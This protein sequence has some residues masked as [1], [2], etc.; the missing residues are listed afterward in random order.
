MCKVLTPHE[1]QAVAY[2]RDPDQYLWALWASKESA[3]KAVSKSFPQVT[4]V[5]KRYPVFLTPN[6]FS[7]ISNGVVHTP[8]GVARVRLF[9]HEAYVHCVGFYNDCPD[10]N[11]IVWGVEKTLP[12]ISVE[13]GLLPAQQSI[14]VRQVAAKSIA[15]QLNLD[16]EQIQIKRKKSSRGLGPPIVYVNGNR[17]KIDISLSHHGRFGAYVFWNLKNSSCSI[18]Q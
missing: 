9:I 12:N 1:K 5:P 6:P 8:H 13:G 16:P 11:N 7:M 14:M 3:Y 2:S 4:A 17:S 18:K 15:R 10:L